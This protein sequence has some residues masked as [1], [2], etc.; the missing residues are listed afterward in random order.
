MTDASL[1]QTKSAQVVTITPPATATPAATTPA[2]TTPAGTP[3]ATTPAAPR[4]GDDA[5][6]D[7]PDR[8]DAEAGR[9][10]GSVD[11]RADPDAAVGDRARG[12]RHRARGNRRGHRSP[13]RPGGDPRRRPGGR[14]ARAGRVGPRARRAGRGR[15]LSLGA[16]ARGAPRIDRH[17]RTRRAPRQPDRGRTLRG[18]RPARQ[19]GDRRPV[20]DSRGQVV[21]ITTRTIPSIVP[22]TVVALPYAS[23]LRIGKAL[24]DGGRVRR[25]YLGL[26]T[27]GITP[28]R[29]DELQLHTSTGVLIR[30][31]VPGSPAAFSTLRGPT[32][33]RRSAADSSRRAR[34]PS[35]RSTDARSRARGSRRRT[36]HDEG[37]PPGRAPGDPRHAVLRRARDAHRPLRP[38]SGVT[39]R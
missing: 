28:N 32:A 10:E 30:R 9:A 27:V 11:H 2:G 23:A 13:Q 14:A 20:V 6:R 12:G 34:T 7:D 5:G 26:E 19:P 25:A 16:P 24:V 17:D 36:R 21:G 3:R 39:G 18:E 29:A 35:R 38:P 37:R 1:V 8:N 22:V 15:R 33:T 31:R 4:R